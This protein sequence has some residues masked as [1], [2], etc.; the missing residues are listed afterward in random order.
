MYNLPPLQIYHLSHVIHEI[1]FLCL[2]FSH[3]YI[4]YVGLDVWIALFKFSPLLL[5]AVVGFEFMYCQGL[6]GKMYSGA[7][8]SEVNPFRINLRYTKTLLCG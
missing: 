6:G 4:L 8:Y 5:R 7:P 1:I 3:V 2:A